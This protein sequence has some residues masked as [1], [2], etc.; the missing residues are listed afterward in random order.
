MSQKMEALLDQ[1][2]GGEIS[3][4][5]LIQRMTVAAVASSGFTTLLSSTAAEAACN[6][7]I[8]LNA[9]EVLIERIL[10]QK[11]VIVPLDSPATG[12]RICMVEGHQIMESQYAHAKWLFDGANSL[13]N[14]DGNKKSIT[15]DIK[16]SAGTTTHTGKPVNAGELTTLKATLDG[17]KDPS[18][19]LFPA[20]N[21]YT[22]TNDYGGQD[23]PN[24]LNDAYELLRAK[25]ILTGEHFASHAV[26]AMM[27]FLD[28][29][30]VCPDLKSK[31]KTEADPTRKALCDY[32]A[33]ETHHDFRPHN[34]EFMWRRPMF[35]ERLQNDIMAAP[36]Q[37]DTW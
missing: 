6:D 2:E 19:G 13:R 11:Y 33:E 18:V 27:N 23:D 9:R 10:N 37:H 16:N 25:I 1:F 34:A 36:S 3:R 29:T 21:A 26:I 8:N 30:N 5:E 35:S 7:T 14:Y 24:Y 31:L 28:A 15:D 17:A 4:R 20:K 12:W 22:D 32:I